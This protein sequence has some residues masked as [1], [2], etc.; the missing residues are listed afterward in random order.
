MKIDRE[1][2]LQFISYVGNLVLNLKDVDNNVKM[3]KAFEYIYQ[4]MIRDKVRIEIANINAEYFKKID[5][6]D[7]N[8]FDEDF[9]N[10]YRTGTFEVQSTSKSYE[11]KLLYIYSGIQ[12]NENK[13]YLVSFKELGVD[14][15]TGSKIE[16]FEKKSAFPFRFSTCFY[17]IYKMCQEHDLYKDNSLLITPTIVEGVANILS[18]FDES[19]HNKVPETYYA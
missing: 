15:L 16:N 9:V 2:S 11:M 17:D 19:K 10:L 14:V 13:V 7:M 6:A 5:N 12:N 3:S 4:N 18:A 8:L 1:K